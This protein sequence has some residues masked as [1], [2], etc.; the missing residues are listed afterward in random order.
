MGA[1][2]GGL[3]AN[4]L[5]CG[6]PRVGRRLG[7]LPS[8]WSLTSQLCGDFLD[9]QLWFCLFYA[10]PGFTFFS[11]DL[12]LI[13]LPVPLAVFPLISDSPVLCLSIS[14]SLSPGLFLSN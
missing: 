4:E 6:Q 13:F 14:L 7:Y 9:V 2:G 1:G 12:S 10:S 3:E 11:P 8:A 5:G